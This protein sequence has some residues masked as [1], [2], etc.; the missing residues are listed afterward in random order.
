MSENEKTTIKPSEAM[1]SVVIATSAKSVAGTYGPQLALRLKDGRV[2][3]I[4]TKSGIA[5][6]L[7]SGKLSMPLRLTGTTVY[8]KPYTDKEGVLHNSS[9]QWALAPRE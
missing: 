8:G 2:A 1:D 6:G 5:K 4:S 3:Y 7:A 9:V